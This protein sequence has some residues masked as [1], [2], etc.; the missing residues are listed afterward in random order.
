MG[1]F[2]GILSGL[3]GILGSVIGGS[4]NAKAVKKASKAQ[5]AGIQQAIDEQRREF[6]LT[7]QDYQPWTSAGTTA[8]G[9]LGDLVGLNGTVKAQA[10]MDALRNSPQYQ[11]LYR[12]GLEANLQNASATGGIR[13]GNEVRSLADFGAD[14]FSQ[15]LND[16]LSRLGGIAGSGAQ[17]VSGLGDQRAAMA[18]NVSSGLMGI[19][20][21]KANSIIGQQQA[22]NNMSSQ[23]SQI[24]SNIPM[25][26]F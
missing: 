22:W 2:G 9:Q 20:N 4:S 21:S 17:M 3:G 7:R 5:Q 10:A 26:G 23:I 16:Q 18:N 13:G 19:G 6:D 15:V 8:L 12:N 1:L 14:T 11:S 24:L 25:G